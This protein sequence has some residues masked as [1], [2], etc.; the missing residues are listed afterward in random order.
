MAAS[1]IDWPQVESSLRASNAMLHTS[2]DSKLRRIARL[3]KLP[4]N[5][6]LDQ[7]Q[8]LIYAMLGP[9][10]PYVGQLG[11]REKPRPPIRR[12]NEHFQR[13][14]A[15]AGKYLGQ[16]HRKLRLFKGFGRN[17]SLQRVLAMHGPATGTIF[18]LQAA[19]PENACQLENAWETTLSPT[20]NQITPQMDF[21]NVL[22]DT[23][24]NKTVAPGRCR[25]MASKV[26]T[27]LTAQHNVITAAEL[28][29]LV[30][31]SKGLLNPNQ[32]ERLWRLCTRRV[33]AELQLTIPRRLMIPMPPLTDS[34]TQQVQTFVRAVLQRST[35]PQTVKRLV[36]SVVT[37]APKAVRRVADV[38][39]GGDRL[40]APH[41]VAQQ[42]P[43]YSQST[44]IIWRGKEMGFKVQEFTKNQRDNLL[45]RIRQRLQ[46]TQCACKSLME[47]HPVL[48]NETGHVVC[49]T[50]LQWQAVA[51]PEIAHILA[52]HARQAIIPS[53]EEVSACV[54]STFETISSLFSPK[55][56]TEEAHRTC[57]FPQAMI[58]KEQERMLRICEAHYSRLRE[59]NP[60]LTVQRI[61][62]MVQEIH[63][64]GLRGGCWDKR[65]Y[66][67]YGV[68]RILEEIHAVEDL[69]LGKRFVVWGWGE[70][71]RTA[72]AVALDEILERARKGGVLE[73]ATAH[74]L[75]HPQHNTQDMCRT[76]LLNDIQT[77]E[78]TGREEG[79]QDRTPETVP[80]GG[81][82]RRRTKNA[83]YHPLPPRAFSIMKWKTDVFRIPPLVKWR[84]VFAFTSVVVQSYAKLIGRCLRLLLG[85]M[86]VTLDT[87]ALP[88]MLGVRD[89][90][91]AARKIQPDRTKM[92][93][94]E[95]DIDDMYWEID[96]NECLHAIDF[97][98]SKVRKMRREKTLTFALHRSGDKSLDRIGSSVCDDFYLLTAS[99]VSKFVSWDLFENTIV[100]Y[101]RL[102]LQQGLR[103]VPIGGHLAGHCA[104]LWA[105]VREHIAFSMT[106]E[107]RQDRQEAWQAEVNHHNTVLQPL[108]TLPGADTFVSMENTQ[109]ADLLGDIWAAKDRYR[110]RPEDV[111]QQGLGGWWNPSLRLLAWMSAHQTD[112][113]ILSTT[114]WDSAPGGRVQHILRQTPRRDVERA[115]D[116]L[117]QFAPY[118]FVLAELGVT[119]PQTDLMYPCTLLAR[120]RDNIYIF[121]MNIPDEWRADVLTCVMALLK[122]IYNV[123]LKWE[124]HGPT[125][126]WCEC[127][128]PPTGRLRLLRKGVVLDLTSEDLGWR[129]WDRWLPA[130][131]PNAGKVIKGQMPA[132][133]QKSLWYAL[134]WQDVHDNLRSLFW[135]LGFHAYA[136]AW[137]MAP[138]NRFLNANGLRGRFPEAL[139]DQW[140]KQGRERGMALREKHTE[141]HGARATGH[142]AHGE[143]DSHT[144][145]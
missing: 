80:S 144:R 13:A 22:W 51:S 84:D 56:G 59:L 52:G 36:S 85:E 10:C 25:D 92:H 97:A 4:H 123:P 135:G 118:E 131:A 133:M 63:Q 82:V 134:S 5:T 21:A 93:L 83:R 110:A 12:W 32:Y 26:N 90:V 128:I 138:T 124:V 17:P 44:Q 113:P 111:R 142:Q 66:R 69:I 77:R 16:K 39:K 2:P 8:I 122:T 101:G 65:L 117:S 125:V 24:I 104:E 132:L 127:A 126:E 141:P 74:N 27:V 121:L 1:P 129:E 35:V 61:Q 29:N 43:F 3:A 68:C 130:T 31:V 78:S 37:C 53:E 33:H 73:L 45:Y 116:F 14:K 76:A 6:P 11:A 88:V 79:K 137:W 102:I 47:R 94:H 62:E 81:Q 28:C 112:I 54:S 42:L 23:V 38:L 30:V 41:W 143:E 96:K 50:E 105:C 64:Q 98:I 7:D 55:E 115:R 72:K 91:Q 100:V 18:P 103:G 34:L 48:K 109:S 67:M 57:P 106:S 19:T 136:V 119:A 15:L 75:G 139:V 145:V 60:N 40:K 99:E 108:V 95:A 120:F 114:L 9:W 71:E 20:T 87:L 89:V 140:Y 46:N 58:E 49:R 86:Y 107:D 70:S